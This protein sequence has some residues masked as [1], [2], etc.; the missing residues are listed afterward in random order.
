VQSTATRHF[1]GT[2]DLTKGTTAGMIGQ[3]DIDRLQS[4]LKAVPFTAT[5][6]TQGRISNLKIDLSTVDPSLASVQSEFSDYGTTVTVNRPDPAQVV[7]AP[8][9]VYQLFKK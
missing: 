1:S 5:T 7:E 4:K 6:D 8:D 2:L 3:A 9:S